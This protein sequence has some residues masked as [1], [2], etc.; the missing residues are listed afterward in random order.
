MKGLSVINQLHL[1]Y[2]YQKWPLR[3]DWVII[4]QSSL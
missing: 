4:S 2:H 3:L 1:S